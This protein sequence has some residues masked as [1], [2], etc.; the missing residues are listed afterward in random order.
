MPTYIE[1]FVI[2]FVS[3]VGMKNEVQEI[4]LYIYIYKSIYKPN[5]R[6]SSNKPLD[7]RGGNSKSFSQRVKTSS[8]VCSSLTRFHQ[9]LIRLA[10]LWT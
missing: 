8:S 6:Y 1:N 7:E 5:S 10:Y 9:A 3:N 4:S 2:K